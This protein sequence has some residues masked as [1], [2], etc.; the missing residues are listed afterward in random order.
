M[1]DWPGARAP[2]WRAIVPLGARRQ[3]TCASQGRALARTILSAWARIQPAQMGLKAQIVEVIHTG[4]PDALSD[5]ADTIPR[6]GNL[7][8]RALALE[9][10]ARL[11]PSEARMARAIAAYEAWGATAVAARLRRTPLG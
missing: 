9:Y 6:D 7:Q 8:D 5:L 11:A 3:T 2:G 1:S 10:A 4:Q